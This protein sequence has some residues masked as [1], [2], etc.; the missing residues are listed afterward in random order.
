VDQI[1]AAINEV[2]NR[3]GVVELGIEEILT[4][5]LAYQTLMQIQSDFQEFSRLMDEVKAIAANTAGD[6]NGIRAKRINE[7]LQTFYLRLLES[8]IDQKVNLVF[9]SL[10]ASIANKDSLMRIVI[11]KIEEKLKSISL[12]DYCLQITKLYEA[13]VCAILVDLAKGYAL[14]SQAAQFIN[15]KMSSKSAEMPYTVEEWTSHY[16]QQ[17]KRLLDAFNTEVERMV[18]LRS[19][20]FIGGSLPYVLDYGAEFAFAS[21]D[22]FTSMMLEE[23][24]GIRGRIFS[25]GDRFS[26]KIKLKAAWSDEFSGTKFEIN[27]GKQYDWWVAR[28]ADKTVYDEVR[29]SD[30]W[31]V[32]RYH[33]PDI[34]DGT[35]AL[36]CPEL[37]YTPGAVLVDRYDARTLQKLP[38]GARPDSANIYYFGSFTEVQRAG[39][40]FALLS[41]GWSDAKVEDK[42]TGGGAADKKLNVGKAKVTVTNVK[43]DRW[44]QAYEKRVA[45]GLRT[46]YPETTP[47]LRAFNRINLNVV[48]AVWGRIEWKAFSAD[49]SWLTRRYSAATES[50]KKIASPD[51][52]KVKLTVHFQDQGGESLGDSFPD[53]SIRSKPTTCAAKFHFTTTIA[54]KRGCTVKSGFG[55]T[56]TG[57]TYSLSKDVKLETPASQSLD[58][59]TV[60]DAGALTGSIPVLFEGKELS[61]SAEAFV[62]YNIET[63]GLDKTE[64]LG[65]GR[66]V[67]DSVSLEPQ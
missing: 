62:D 64:Y 32:Y 52:R 51:A 55:L 53:P 10:T 67:I 9:T 42:H 14:Y 13:Y 57:H 23:P 7:R 5:G 34:L 29:F 41:G 39:G 11:T 58:S 54:T 16:K 63:S 50:K 2:L 24:Y 37:P 3:L 30:T 18:L 33:I 59:I 47:T 60:S 65:V 15:M 31:K 35:H 8:K 45:P 26:G 21:A 20:K 44:L 17:K 36:T 48:A 43:S 12:D 38:V 49:N 56:F 27:L 1:N 46:K 22:H 61:L 4:G 66:F 28:T 19:S 40:A 6:P 25:M